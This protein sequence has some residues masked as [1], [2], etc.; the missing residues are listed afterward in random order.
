V[1]VN[2][3]GAT[4]FL[5][6]KIKTAEYFE[7]FLEQETEQCRILLD[8]ESNQSLSLISP[9]P[10]TITIL[11]GPEGGF[12]SKERDRAYTK[13]YQGIQLGPRILRTETAAIA[14]ISAI[15]SLWG[16]FL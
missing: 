3:L 5:K 6:L 7:T 14:T 13:G 11:I 15:Q 10:S 16:D 1:P 2:N 4:N 12:S 8:P 9:K